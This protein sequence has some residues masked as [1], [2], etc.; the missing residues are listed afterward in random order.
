MDYKDPHIVILDE[1]ERVPRPGPIGRVVF[2]HVLYDDCAVGGP[3]FTQTGVVL[4]ILIVR[5]LAQRLQI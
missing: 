2:F 1:Y 4:K 5:D 3:N